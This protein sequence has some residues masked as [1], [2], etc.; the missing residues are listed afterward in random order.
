MI[1]SVQERDV[2]MIDLNQVQQD[3]LSRQLVRSRRTV[4]ANAMAKQK[5]FH[6]PDNAAPED[7]EML[8]SE[9]VYTGY[10]DAG[11]V[12]PDLRCECGRPLRYQHHVEHKK[13][14]EIMKFGIDHLKEHLGIDASVVAAVKKG[15]DAIDYELDELL[16]KFKNNWLPDPNLL[17]HPKLPEDVLSHLKYNL[18]LLERQ[19]KRLRQL[20][21]ELA[22]IPPVEQRSYIPPKTTREPIDLFTWQDVS[23]VKE[24]PGPDLSSSLKAPV[25]EYLLSGVRSVRVICELLIKEHGAADIRFLTGKQHIY[26]ILSRRPPSSTK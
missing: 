7:I 6:I 14:R 5:G 25:E 22:P 8:L 13:T 19:L 18:P 9:W 20:R 1:L 2:L 26:H 4:F 15:F 16:L 10:I 17:E 21:A 24:I 3:F 11:H 12:S 23:P